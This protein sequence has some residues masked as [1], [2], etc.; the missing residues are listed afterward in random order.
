MCDDVARMLCRR[1]ALAACRDA[2]FEGVARAAL[3][4]LEDVAT[5]YLATL[6]RLARASADAAGRS[7]G[8]T[9]NDVG[10]ALHWLAVDID[11]LA[12]WF[13]ATQQPAAVPSPG[14]AAATATAVTRAS[15]ADVPVRGA[16]PLDW[17]PPFPHPKPAPAPSA[18]A[19]A[20]PAD[21]REIARGAAPA[22]VPPGTVYD[23]T[24][25]PSLDEIEVALAAYTMQ[26][27]Q[28]RQA[29]EQARQERERAEAAERAAAAAAAAAPQKKKKLAKAKQR[30]LEAAE[31]A[32]AEAKALREN[33]GV[34]L[35]GLDGELAL[36]DGEIRERPATEDAGAAAAVGAA[37]PLPLAGP[38]AL[39]PAA[40]AGGAGPAARRPSSARLG[41]RLGTAADGGVD[42][43]QLLQRALETAQRIR[44]R[45]D[46]EAA[47]RAPLRLPGLVDSP[48]KRLR[49]GSDAG[50]AA[51]LS[52][53]I[54]LTAPSA[55]PPAVPPPSG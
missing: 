6:A 7:G 26:V 18:A 5:A 38:E 33:W 15:A 29:A 43:D 50:T 55:P 3:E 28:L 47:A 12:V 46:L 48:A 16:H 44:S 22:P 4:T 39:A 42:G 1:A 53:R 25:P 27:E 24:Q 10:A 37:V 20:A 2:Q 11:E 14:P 41:G 45:Q 23:L 36:G 17:A 35:P 49:A 21:V 8:P 51:P 19:A 9:L 30:A 31:K 32:A 54:S 40:V 52:L 34:K 13:V